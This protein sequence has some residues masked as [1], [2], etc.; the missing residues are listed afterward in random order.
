MSPRAVSVQKLPDLPLWES[1]FPRDVLEQKAR[2]GDEGGHAMWLQGFRM[3]VI[4]PGDL[5]FPSFKLCCEPGLIVSEVR[6]RMWPAYVGVDLSSATR[7]GNFIVVV[8]VEPT[9][10]RRIVAEVVHGAWSS[11]ETAMMLADVCGRHNVQYVMVEN[12]AY[13]GSLI[14]WI[15]KGKTAYPSLWMKVEA[16]T[17]GKNKADP[18]FG[19]PGLEVEFSNRAW[20][21]PSGEWEGHPEGHDCSWCVFFRQFSLYPKYSTTDGVMAAWFCKSAIDQWG[22]RRIAGDGRRD[23]NMR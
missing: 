8:V 5:K 6:R 22:N 1:K 23:L 12:N 15:Q 21:F 9:T 2:G 3:Q 11:P 18:A 10:R 17:T 14:D 16:H 13:Q 19:L 7:P 20:S 4:K